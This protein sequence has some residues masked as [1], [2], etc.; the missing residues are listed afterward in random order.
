MSWRR[1]NKYHAKSVVIDGI[2][3]P[4]G[5]EGERFLYLRE[6]EKRGEIT[7]LR[8][9]VRFEL[10]PAAY[11]DVVKHLKTKDKVVRRLFLNPVAYVADFVYEKDGQTVVEDTKGYKTPEY[12]IK[13]KMMYALKGIEIQ[14]I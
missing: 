12:V 8:R 6:L 5:K 2:K 1:G 3:F 13:K 14:E 11:K 9:Q 10:L 4:S 7:N